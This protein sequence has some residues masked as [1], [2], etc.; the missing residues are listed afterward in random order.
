[1]RKI[2]LIAFIVINLFASAFEV[3]KKIYTII[4]SVIFPKHQQI[5]IWSDDK[6]NERLFKSL[7][8]NIKIVKN[9]NQADILFIFHTFGIKTKKRVFVG[10]YS[11]LKEYKNQAIGGFYWQKGRPNLIFLH[12]NV[13]FFHIKLPIDLK[14]FEEDE[15]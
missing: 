14:E 1:M 6:K 11:L 3:E 10:R 4:L 15:I 12:K 2:F 9:K 13:K 8:L 5:K 7:P